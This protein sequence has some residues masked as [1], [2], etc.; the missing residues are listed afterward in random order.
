ML[1]DYEQI[2]E[3][4]VEVSKC[5]KCNISCKTIVCGWP[6]YFI[7]QKLLCFNNTIS[8]IAMQYSGKTHYANMITSHMI[9]QI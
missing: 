9:G 7:S 2:T 4:W 3:I 5:F 6:N 1:F 8:L